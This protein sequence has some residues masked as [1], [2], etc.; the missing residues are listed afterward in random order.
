MSPSGLPSANVETLREWFGIAPD[1]MLAVDQ[2]GGIVLANALAEQMFGYAAGALCGLE[3][4]TLVPENLRDVHRQHR[5]DFMA[6]PQVRVIETERELA[7][8]RRDGARFPIGVSLSPVASAQGILVIASVRDISRTWRA[9]QVLERARRDRFVLQIGRLAVESPEY[10]HAIRRIPELVATALGVPMVAILSTDWHREGLHVRSSSGLSAQAAEVLAA[11]FA[12][13]RFIRK[14][15]VAG[16]PDAVTTETLC[17]ER[18]AS[19]RANLAAAGFHDIAMVPL[20]GRDEPLGALVAIA[21]AGFGFDPDRVG[22]LQSV[23]NLL[24]AAVQRSRSEEQLAHSQRLDAVGQLTGGVA[25]DFNNLLTV[26]SGNLQLLEATAPTDPSVRE[27]IDD[28]LRAVDRGAELTRRLLAFS[29]RQPL[30]P[31]AVVPKPLLEELGHMLRRTLGEMITVEIGCDVTVPDVY[32][33]AN[34]LDTALVNLALNARDAMTRGGRLTITAREVTVA[35]GDNEWK[36]PP[37]RYV[38]FDVVDTGTGMPPEVQAH[39]LEPFFT[40]KDPGKG[41]GLGLSMVYG[42][43]TQSGGAMGIDSRLGYGTRVTF[44]LPAAGTEMDRPAGAPETRGTF[45]SRRATILVVE[46]ETD[47]RTVAT[48]FLRA[49]GYEV[50]AVSSAREALAA[51]LAQP[52]IDLLFSDVVL[53]SGTNGVELAQEARRMRPGL[54]VLLTSGYTRAEGAHGAE[55]GIEAFEL[56]HKPYR[57]EQLVS[58]IQRLLDGA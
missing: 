8:M 44:V 23:A 32:A 41:S 20:F 53:G 58:A 47:V 55:Q 29:R 1:A 3:L 7:G 14:T 16:G 57:R 51:L 49:I 15:F 52:G 19:V 56:L 4:E 11:T 36:L 21:P 12:N 40:T 39:A 26:I 13:V 22:F 38:G 5:R 35:T 9:R 31:R 28:A 18:H 30:E 42:F 17:D 6:S 33:D 34:E 54:A 46:D 45:A 25:H 50:I 37:G 2:H 27:V 43:V 48:R 24:A 10:E